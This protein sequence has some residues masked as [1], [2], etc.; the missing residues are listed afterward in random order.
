MTGSHVPIREKVGGMANQGRVIANRLR[1]RALIRLE[2]TLEQRQ[3]CND[4]Q[5][6]RES[7]PE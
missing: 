5:L 1:S 4:S 7:M 6:I 2:L 3:V